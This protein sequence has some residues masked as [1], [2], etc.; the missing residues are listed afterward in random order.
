MADASIQM[1]RNVNLDSLFHLG[2]PDNEFYW[3][4]S[5]DLNSSFLILCASVDSD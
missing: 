4:Q 5:V 3:I 1:S 2:H